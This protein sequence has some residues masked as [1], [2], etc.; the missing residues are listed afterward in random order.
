M[1]IKNQ[2]KGV[3]FRVGALTKVKIKWYTIKG[4]S[5]TKDREYKNANEGR[6]IQ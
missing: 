6:K 2:G 5:K 4:I 3:F 1:E